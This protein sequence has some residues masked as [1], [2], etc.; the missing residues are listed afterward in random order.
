MR[1]QHK[2]HGARKLVVPK[3]DVEHALDWSGQLNQFNFDQECEF[4]LWLHP[5]TV[6]R[7]RWSRKHSVSSHPSHLWKGE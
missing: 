5:A 4:Q 3:A 1:T 6:G 7:S 2:R